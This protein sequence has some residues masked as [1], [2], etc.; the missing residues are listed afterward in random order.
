MSPGA[1]SLGPDRRKGGIVVAARHAKAAQVLLV[2]SRTTCGWLA[3][4]EKAALARPSVLPD[5]D[6]RTLVG[7]LVLVHS[8]LLETLA[9]PSWEPA[10]PVWEYVRRH[11]HDSAAIEAST[12]ELTGPMSELVVRLDEAIENL[13]TA[14]AGRLPP[15][16]EAPR[17]PISV[18]D[19]LE[20]RVVEVVVHADDLT[21]SLPERESVRLERGALS[22]CCRTLT[23]ILAAQQPGRSVEVRVPP[24]AAVQCGLADD[25]GPTHTRGTPPNVVETDPVTFVRLAT[26][27]LSW[28]EAREARL[29]KASG[30]R[31]NLASVL[32][33]IS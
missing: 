28:D 24:F 4:V 31:A 21:R 32:P 18:L 25:P 3:R 8:G 13:E 26:G 17:G 27:R 16:L 2:Q 11:G 20:T 10:V 19:F 23:A 7:H 22:A 12:P 6:V 29:V 14:L 5:W 9:R 30:Q 15:V 33:L 1:C